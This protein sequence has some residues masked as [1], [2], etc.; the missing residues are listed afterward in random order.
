MCIKNLATTHAAF[1]VAE[2]KI[3]PHSNCL[4]VFLYELI[5]SSYVII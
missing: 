1:D 4:K 2:N 5:L 3:I